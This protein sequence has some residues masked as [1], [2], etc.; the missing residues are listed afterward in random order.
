MTKSAL[1]FFSF[2]ARQIVFGLLVAG[3]ISCQP[4]RQIQ[5]KQLVRKSQVFSNQFTGFCLFDLTENKYLINQNENLYFTP[6]SNM[7]ILTALQTLRIFGDSLP[8]FAVARIEDS[9]IVRPLGDPTFLHPIFPLQPAFDFLAGEQALKIIDGEKKIP[10]FG[11]GWAWDD[12]QYDYQA[13][14][15][16]FPIYGNVVH[17][18]KTA[19]SL[20]VNPA[21]FRDF[22]NVTYGETIEKEN[23]RDERYNLF[24]IRIPDQYEDFEREVPF[25]YTDELLVQLLKDTL[26]V[27]ITLSD[28]YHGML[29][30]TIYNQSTL[31][32]VS[33]MMQTSD[34]FLAEQLLI[35]AALVQGYS[36][37]DQYRIQVLKEWQDFNPNHIQWYDASGL[38][39]YNLITPKS[40][41]SILSRIYAEVPWTTIQRVF[42]T[43][44]KSGTIANWYDSDPPFVFAKTGTLSNNHSLSGYLITDS[45]NT[46]IFSLMNNHYVSSTTPV[47]KEMERMLY[48]IKKNF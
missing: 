47:K 34:N 25:D 11:P 10:G 1:D 27:G 39:R 30:D 31:A 41:V 28:H 19:D 3:F 44:G 43:G 5:V 17:F 12:F 20:Y 14:R 46:L 7:K 48:F 24:S 40:L 4:I 36:D 42:P 6:A 23:S 29:K 15:S 38:S 2:R 26:N 13:E 33:H 35:Q 32:V 9:L 8:T 37:I 18:T 45:G 21:F 16:W 22:V